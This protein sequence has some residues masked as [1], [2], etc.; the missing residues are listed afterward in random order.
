YH[1]R[2]CA[3]VLPG[4]GGRELL[5]YELLWY[6]LDDGPLDAGPERAACS[7]IRRNAS[8]A[9]ARCRASRSLRSRWMRAPRSEAAFSRPARA[10]GSEVAS[11]ARGLSSG[12]RGDLA[13]AALRADSSAC[14]AAASTLL[15]GSSS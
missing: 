1:S 3:S 8:S 2:S 13:R 6:E 5:W 10:A 11:R 7:F 12:L 14:R 4:R 15:S 9:A